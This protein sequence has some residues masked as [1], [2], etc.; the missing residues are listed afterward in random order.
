MGFL[1]LYAKYSWPGSMTKSV[2]KGYN[3]FKNKHPHLSENDIYHEIIKVRY[4]NKKDKYIYDEVAFRIGN[5]SSLYDLINEILMFESK[6]FCSLDVTYK[7][8][9]REAVKDI[10]KSNGLE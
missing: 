4:A 7:N 3:V 9:I 8:S 10:L 2:I 5:Y 6:G 1:K